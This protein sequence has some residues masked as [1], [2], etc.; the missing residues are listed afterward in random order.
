MQLCNIAKVQHTRQ[1]L[2]C[3]SDGK[4]LD[5]AGP[6]RHHVVVERSQGKS[7]DTVKEA[8]HRQ[9]APYMG[10]AHFTADTTVRVML[11]AVWAV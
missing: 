8:A 6:Q 9:H 5:L 7:A 10:T 4:R 3:D 1:S 2:Y 11:T